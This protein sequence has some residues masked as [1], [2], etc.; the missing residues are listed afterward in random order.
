[1]NLHRAA[2]L[3]TL[4]AAACSSEG[5]SPAGAGGSTAGAG[6]STAGAAGSGGSS[7]AGSGATGGTSAAGAGGS[8]AAE[9]PPGPYGNQVG[10]V[11]P[12]LEWQGYVNDSAQGK[13]NAQPLGPYSSAAL[14]ASGKRLAFVHLSEFF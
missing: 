13:A 3:S 1:M 5:T 6:G 9:Y 10:D 2:V 12:P 7:A 4:L 14:Q 8:M 11:F